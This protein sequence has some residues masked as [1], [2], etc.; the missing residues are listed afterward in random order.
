MYQ[1]LHIIFIYLFGITN[2]KI[3]I[4][5]VKNLSKIRPFLLLGLLF[6]FTTANVIFAEPLNVKNDQ[7]VVLTTTSVLASIVRDLASDLVTTHYIVSPSI[8]PGHYDVKPSDIELIRSASLLL[9]HGMEWSSWLRELINSAN[10]TGDLHIPIYNITGPWNTP[11]YLRE[12][13]SMIASILENEFGFDLS[14]RLNSCLQAINDTDE[15]LKSMAEMYNFNNTPVVSMLWQ[16]GFI[17]YL[18]FKVVATYGPPEFLSSQDIVELENNATKYGAKLIIDNLHSGVE[19]GEK[20]AEDIGI[21]HV[22]LINFPEAVPSIKNVTDMMIY[23][24]KML[25]KGLHDYEN[26]HEIN[27]LKN[28]VKFWSYVSIGLGLLLVIE[29]II[30]VVLVRRSGRA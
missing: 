22:V 29:T 18:G 10:Q 6:F 7:P 16:A 2:E 11:P 1:Y 30:I 28:D 8:C 23:N 9:A 21:A 24:A 19:I 4:T 17:S 26:A 14:D 13:Y 15:T 20:I 27:S 3:S 5:L 25:I 12:K